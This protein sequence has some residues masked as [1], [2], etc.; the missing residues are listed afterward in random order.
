MQKAGVAKELVNLILIKCPLLTS[1]KLEAIRAAGKVPTT[2]DTYESMTKS[3]YAIA[4]GI[5]AAIGEINGG[6]AMETLHTEQTWSAKASC[7]SGAELE[8]LPYLAI[9]IRSVSRTTSYFEL[10][11]G[12]H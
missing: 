11:D 5:A 3:R 6:E 12:C 4:V 2:T 1:S 10:H 7:R 8:D 9:G